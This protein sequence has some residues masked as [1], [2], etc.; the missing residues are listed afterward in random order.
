M[1]DL[2]KEMK[3]YNSLKEFGFDTQ[4]FATLNLPDAPNTNAA[5]VGK[6]YLLYINIGTAFVPVW[7]VIGGQ[8]GATLNQSAEEIDVGSKSSGGWGEKL[9]GMR[10]W[11]IDLDGLVL[12]NNEGIEALRI[13]FAQGK[14]VNIK[15]RYPD[16]SYQIGWAAL[17]DF[18]SEMPHDGEASLSGTLSG[19]GPLSNIS[20]KVSKTA[21]TD[22]TFVFEAKALATTV[23]LA[24]V[25]VDAASYDKTVE[26]EITF[27]SDY[28]ESLAVGEHL[29][30]VDLSI[31]GQA[32]VALDIAA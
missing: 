7:I 28:L 2:I 30:Y 17:T 12:L 25:A 23:Q 10:S 6:D 13:A 20:V 19:N 16:N 8:R 26:G 27:D 11:S 14:K 3:V 24:G 4:L 21:A 32:L 5:T 18:S 29:F 1:S 31:G 9:P 22:Q 15:L